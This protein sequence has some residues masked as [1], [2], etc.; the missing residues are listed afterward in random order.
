MIALINSLFVIVAILLIGVVLIQQPKTSGGLFSGTSQ[1][2]L[3]TG[4]KTFW[5]KFTVTVAALFM[6]LCLILNVLPRY[7]QQESA[8]MGVIEKQQ[9]A[10]AAPQAN[11]PVPSSVNSQNKLPAGSVPAPSQNLPGSNLP[12]K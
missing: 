8:V 5:V 7:Q 12:K 1:S 10:A 2:L 4:G 11:A 6:L 3:G 9:K